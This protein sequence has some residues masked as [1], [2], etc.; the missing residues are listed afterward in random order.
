MTV[1]V[2]EPA[3]SST[4][5]LPT[6][7]DP[8]A[9]IQ[10]ASR[11]PAGGEIERL[12]PVIRAYAELGLIGPARELLESLASGIV[13]RSE[14]E[15]LLR[16]LAASPSGRVA[17]GTLQRR[18]EGAV[19]SLLNHH[20]NLRRWRKVIESLPAVA[21]IY[22]S[23][24]GSLHLSRRSS[25]GLD[26][27]IGGFI[28]TESLASQI[29]FGHAPGDQFCS[30]YLLCG[31][32]FGA[33]LRSVYRETSRMFMN[34]A[35]RLFV[36]E[37]DPLDLAAAL[38]V[39][40]NLPPLLDERTHLFV[41]ERA[42]EELSELLRSNIGMNLPAYLIC[43]PRDGGPVEKVLS[44]HLASMH[45]ERSLLT[46]KI[47]AENDSY[48]RGRTRMDWA[49]RIKGR[50]GEPLTVLGITSRFTTV[51]QYAMRDVKEAFERAGH[52]FEMLIEQNDH[53]LL[54][55]HSFASAVAE[56][57]PDIIF[58]IDHL[59][60]EYTVVLPANVPYVC[61]IQDLL[62]NLACVEAGRSIGPMD[63]YLSASTTDLVSAYEYPA[64]RG[65]NVTMVTDQTLYSAEPLPRDELA[66]HACDFSFVSN[67]SEP[68]HIFHERFCRDLHDHP[69]VRGLCERL[70]NIMK[71]ELMDSDHPGYPRRAPDL[72]DEAQ[73]P[74]GIE[75][76]GA[77]FTD[78][79]ARRYVQPLGELM[80][81]QK[82]IEWVAAYCEAK[83]L[84]LHLYGHG[85]E[86]HPSF[87]PYARGV[88]Q[89]G[90]TLRAIY[91][92]S[93]I[94]LQV[95]GYGCI[96]QRLLDGLAGG[97]FF[98]IRKTGID[99][100]AGHLRGICESDAVLAPGR[101]YRL[102][103]SPE[104]RPAFEAEG[105][106]AGGRM[107][108]ETTLDHVRLALLRELTEGR[109]VGG[110]VFRDYQ[111]I[112]FSCQ[113]EFISLADQFLED[114]N[115][116]R[117]ISTSMRD[118]VAQR[119]TYAALVAELLDFLSQRMSDGG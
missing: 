81:R 69:E 89:N 85:W 32:C 95:N 34:F 7:R 83:G 96:H 51:L 50:D 106:I 94:N 36:V 17:W 115:A 92:A 30:N 9:I 99:L 26:R 43:V 116:R 49:N 107:A 105:L 11:L 110:A 12:L 82:A 84:K 86:S 79:I 100:I 8:Y 98:L 21:E 19:K 22:R 77:N 33:I 75:P 63:F 38:C 55:S 118:V 59:R 112:A 18:F 45:E 20:A 64:N 10:E 57:K 54:Q 23:N 87:A 3:R 4:Q 113:D 37:A 35:P 71:R 14:C 56:H 5:A 109:R 88:A 1:E 65:Q 119:F 60:R 76:A 27:W 42:M 97:G 102:E 67:Q 74:G 53:D 6:T 46:R 70:F 15:A 68:P 16:P 48:Y 104:L 29:A 25:R 93:K 62:P 101:K 39:E 78:A 52:R 61:W 40:A 2:S 91:Q 24:D 73:L 66:G 90:R 72:L 108:A 117:D 103:D 47:A 80:F 114:E 41:G 28:N 31:D 44:A 111:R 13:D 58:C